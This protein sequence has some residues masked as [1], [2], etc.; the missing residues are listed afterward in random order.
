MSVVGR[1]VHQCGI[2]IPI[3]LHKISIN[4]TLSRYLRHRN[5]E[6]ILILATSTTE[7]L[8]YFPQHTKE[9]V[10]FMRIFHINIRVFIM[11]KTLRLV[12]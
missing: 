4:L 6:L 11:T 10:L 5:T 1:I 3:E 2:M 12:S 7:V 8:V 9:G